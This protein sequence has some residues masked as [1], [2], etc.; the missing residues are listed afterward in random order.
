M[1]I[2][3]CLICFFIY[4][5]MQGF[6]DECVVVV[7]G[8]LLFYTEIQDGREKWRESDFREMSPVDSADNLQVKHFVEIALSR[9]VS[10]INAFLHF[11]Q[12][13]KMAA[14]NCGKTI[15]GK[16]CQ[17]TLKLSCGSQISLKSL[18]LAPFLRY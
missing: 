9:T 7:F 3:L 12:K 2:F 18:Y 4:A 16:S 15:F 8:L 5:Q 6:I 14:K 13:F 11:I 1:T 17:K 10:E